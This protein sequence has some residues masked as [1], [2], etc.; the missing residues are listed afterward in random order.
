M[1]VF[2][3]SKENLSVSLVHFYYSPYSSYFVIV[4][5]LLISLCPSSP[6]ESFIRHARLI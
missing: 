2:M 4:I 6:L 1:N 3:T 5:I